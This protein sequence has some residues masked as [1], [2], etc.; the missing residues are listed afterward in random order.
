MISVENGL[1]E[2]IEFDN[3]LLFPYVKN[4]LGQLKVAVDPSPMA[5]L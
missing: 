1:K 4:L 3:N 2:L 5:F